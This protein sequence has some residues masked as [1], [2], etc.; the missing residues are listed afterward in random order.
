MKSDMKNKFVCVFISI[1]LLLC[2]AGCNNEEEQS[3]K[4]TCLKITEKAVRVAYESFN[5]YSLLADEY[6]KSVSE[7]YFDMMYYRESDNDDYGKLGRDYYE[8]NIIDDMKAEISG[9]Q[10]IVSYLYTYECLRLSDDETLCSKIEF[11]VTITFEKKN[12]DYVIVDY[13]ELP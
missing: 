8:S 13:F 4:D 5:D 6:K 7:Y 1:V 12:N 3:A 10:V 11:P 9:E 2:F